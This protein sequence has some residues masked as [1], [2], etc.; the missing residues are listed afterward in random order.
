MR[1]FKSEDTIIVGKD[2]NL[3]ITDDKNWP[4]IEIET[5]YGKV[6]RPDILIK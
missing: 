3:I 6:L 5:E 2:K 1:G 4:K